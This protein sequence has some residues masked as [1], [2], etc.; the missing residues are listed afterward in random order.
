M[1]V[2]LIGVGS[3]SRL[4]QVLQTNM[5][6]LKEDLGLLGIHT[7]SMPAVA[8]TQQRLQQQ[9]AEAL[10][11]GQSV[12]IVGGIGGGSDLT[13]STVCKG[14]GVQPVA[15]QL[16]YSQMSQR[17]KAA[18]EPLPQG[19]RSGVKVPEGATVFRSHTGG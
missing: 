16:S 11:A 19:A 6:I 13:V 10:N 15:D 12:I 8:D 5:D 14:L 1:T 3:Q 7:P 4:R 2:Q 18:G 9:I 17:C